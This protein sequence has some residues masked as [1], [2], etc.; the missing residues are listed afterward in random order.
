M[1]A[2]SLIQ[3]GLR[4]AND[5]PLASKN[6]RAVVGESKP[7]RPQTDSVAEQDRGQSAVPTKGNDAVVVQLNTSKAS[8]EVA[9][10]RPVAPKESSQ[11]SEKSSLIS[12]SSQDSALAEPSRG[13]SN[14]RTFAK[15]VQAYAYSSAAP[16]PASSEKA[17][18]SVRA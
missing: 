5:G 10:Y 6:L 13:L 4:V 17:S 8:Q 15:G 12:S 3:T 14:A 2:V 16:T 18:L 9:S 7:T 11:V 1:N